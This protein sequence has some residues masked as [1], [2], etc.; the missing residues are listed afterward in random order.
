MIAKLSSTAPLTPRARVACSEGDQMVSPRHLQ[1][2]SK[3]LEDTPGLL[4]K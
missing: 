1:L 4:D 3:V 2:V